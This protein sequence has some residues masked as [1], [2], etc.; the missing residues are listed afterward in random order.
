MSCV[1]FIINGKDSYH[2][3]NENFLFSD[4]ITVTLIPFLLFILI[5]IN[6]ILLDVIALIKNIIDM[7]YYTVIDYD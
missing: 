2:F 5:Q 6:V 4:F 1:S 3:I 7:F